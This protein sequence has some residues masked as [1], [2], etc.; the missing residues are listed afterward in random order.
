MRAEL[1]VENVPEYAE[2]HPYWIVT[3]DDSKERAWFY[4]AWD[5][6]EETRIILAQL[7]GDRLIVFNSHSKNKERVFQNIVVGQGV[8]E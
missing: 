5:S 3:L 2:E 4:G 6:I 1:I 8:E 7:G